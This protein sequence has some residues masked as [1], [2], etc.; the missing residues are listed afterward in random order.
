MVGRS[1]QGAWL[2]THPALD[3]RQQIGL[4]LVAVDDH[5]RLVSGLQFVY[6]LGCP[7]DVIVII[8]I[9]GRFC[10]GLVGGRQECFKLVL[11]FLEFFGH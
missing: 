1:G 11:E 4:V 7:L 8:T 5:G 2:G 10:A 9:N 6:F 3:A